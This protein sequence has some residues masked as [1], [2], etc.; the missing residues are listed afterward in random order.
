MFNNLN[1]AVGQFYQDS[2]EEMDNNLDEISKLIPGVEEHN[3]GLID[4]MLKI[5]QG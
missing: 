3:P 1:K 5:L 2:I 4:K